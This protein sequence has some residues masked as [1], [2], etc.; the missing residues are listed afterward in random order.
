MIESDSKFFLKINLE[1]ELKFNGTSLYRNTNI[2]R[3]SGNDLK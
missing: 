2:T 3:F 1:L